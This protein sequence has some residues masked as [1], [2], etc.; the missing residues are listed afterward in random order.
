VVPGPTATLLPPQRPQSRTVTVIPPVLRQV[1]LDSAVEGVYV[2]GQTRELYVFHSDEIRQVGV[3]L[4]ATDGNGP[5][6]LEV[7]LYD[8]NRQIVPRVSAPIG[9]P[10]LRDGWH[11]P[12]PGDYTV[13]VFGPET[14]T[15]TFSLMILS[16]PVP[17]S[18][19][20]RIEYG[21]ARSGEIAVRGQ[22]DR[23][24]FWGE[25]GDYIILTMIAPSADAYLE[26]Y[27]SSGQLI[28]HNDDSSP[29]MHDSV[30]SL[31]LP[32]NGEY[33]VVARM[34]GDDQTGAY[35]LVLQRV[36]PP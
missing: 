8:A 24:V 16:R 30:L 13:Q 1:T 2:P 18:G 5:L 25:A 20:G 15:R 4:T 36:A 19:G 31:V 12:E 17:E 22:R 23:W 35:Q 29:A 7:L 34:Y 6:R 10:L 26:L 11:L 9:Q 28:V 27:S 21:E 32:A 33:L 14:Q 3:R